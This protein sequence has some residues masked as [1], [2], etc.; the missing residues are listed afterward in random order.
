MPVITLPDGTQA[1]FPDGM[2]EDEV[3]D[4][5]KRC[6]PH[7]DC[8]IGYIG[9]GDWYRVARHG[10]AVG[11]RKTIAEAIALSNS[12]PPPQQP[13][14]TPLRQTIRVTADGL[15]PWAGV[16]RAEARRRGAEIRERIKRHRRRGRP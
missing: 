3:A 8:E 10:V 13:R 11:Y 5:L 2:G 7:G 14:T 16:A 1:Q 9:V 4:V 12:L 6:L 15:C